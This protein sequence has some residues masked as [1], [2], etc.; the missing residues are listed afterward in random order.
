[1]QSMRIEDFM[2]ATPQSL[3]GALIGFFEGLPAETQ[4]KLWDQFFGIDAGFPPGVDQKEVSMVIANGCQYFMA[5]LLTGKL[6]KAHQ[7]EAKVTEALNRF[8]YEN[9]TRKNFQKA[10]K[11]GKAVQNGAGQ[12]LLEPNW[13]QIRGVSADDVTKYDLA[14]EESDVNE[15]VRDETEVGGNN[16]SQAPE[17]S[18][19]DSK[20]RK[21][22][23]N[24]GDEEKKPSDPSV[25]SFHEQE[26]ERYNNP[27][28]SFIYRL[29]TGEAR[30]VAPVCKKAMD[31]NV[32]PRDHFLLL[33]DRPCAV[34]ILG[35]VRDA[36]A[37]L[38]QGFGTRG[39]ICELLKESQ[40]INQNVDDEKMSSVVSGALDRLHYE[41]DPCVRYDS[42]RKL[43][44]YLHWPNE[45]SIRN[46][47]EPEDA[48]SSTG[49]PTKSKR[50]KAN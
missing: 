50:V 35:L 8:F 19:K 6:E 33:S 23:I 9:A 20:F 34:T 10:I 31:V 26:V 38:P 7:E 24:L 37:K 5:K 41:T 14:S 42:A 44:I 1:M 32:R 25:P 27:T 29:P 39:A 11:L 46:G 49:E 15:P 12:H 17:G 40:F 21:S 4:S 22:E 3:S 13:D 45:A 16:T 2:K 28:Q 47:N 30:Y 48:P 43:W 36:A 18:E